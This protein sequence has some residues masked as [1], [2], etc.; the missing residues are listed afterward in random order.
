M[1]HLISKGHHPHLKKRALLE[2]FGLLVLVA[3]SINQKDLMSTALTDIKNSK[4]IFIVLMLA[5][6]GFYQR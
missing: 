1:K 6:I 3:I 2:V 4:S 5:L